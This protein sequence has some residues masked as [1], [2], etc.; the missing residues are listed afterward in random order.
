MK[1]FSG[2]RLSN[3]ADTFLLEAVAKQVANSETEAAKAIA[4]VQAQIEELIMMFGTEAQKKT[5]TS[6][7]KVTKV[8]AELE[9]KATVNGE[10]LVKD[11]AEEKV[12]VEA[13][14][15]ARSYAKASAETKKKLQAQTQA[16]I[17]AENKL[18]VEIQARH[19]AEQK[20]KAEAKEFIDKRI[21][22]PRI[23][24]MVYPKRLYWSQW[25][26]KGIKEDNI[27]AVIIFCLLLCIVLSTFTVS[28]Y[29]VYTLLSTFL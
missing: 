29:F 20:A 17:E 25:L 14:E 7:D 4:N 13:E 28:G 6:T 19:R 3:A 10:L 9:E 8:K 5:R 12:T 21:I 22:G 2:H 23:K 1:G 11:E 16:R 15:K 18:K 26:L 27:T 24:E